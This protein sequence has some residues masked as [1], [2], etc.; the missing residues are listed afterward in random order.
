MRNLILFSVLAIALTSCSNVGKYK[1]SI[2]GLAGNWEETT[3][4]VTAM[5]EQING[6]QQLAK[7]AL[8]SMNP[9]E[10]VVA[11]MS[12]EQTASLNGL[13]EKVQSQMAS[14]GELSKT[15]FEFVN[16][17][18]EEGKKLNGLTEGLT[19]GKLPG[20][21]ETTLESLKGMVES[22]NEKVENW[23][24]QVNAAKESVASASQEY[25]NLISSLSAEDA[26]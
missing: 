2:E 16:K 20:D 13:K 4:K 5:V 1:E 18:Q 9:S 17:W 7:S 12:E 19:S 22:A 15:A 6:A 10:E 11:E 25:T 24:E 14:M 23:G 26:E 21:V 3:T 8:A